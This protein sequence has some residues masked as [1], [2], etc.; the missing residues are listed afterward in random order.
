MDFIH[1]VV[2]DFGPEPSRLLGRLPVARV[3]RAGGQRLTVRQ[4]VPD[5]EGR[6]DGPLLGAGRDRPVLQV[7]RETEAPDAAAVAAVALPLRYLLPALPPPGRGGG[8]AAALHVRPRAELERRAAVPH[9]AAPLGHR[10]AR[11]VGEQR[12]DSKTGSV[13]GRLHRRV[14][15]AS[16]YHWYSGKR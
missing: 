6:R 9:Q 4:D 13:S 10:A 16:D 5:E 3:G 2:R 8:R 15:E 12:V 1:E 14:F 11:P 7:L